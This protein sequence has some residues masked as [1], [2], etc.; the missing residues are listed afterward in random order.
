MTSLYVQRAKSS[1]RDWQQADL[2]ETT[3]EI[4]LIVPNMILVD[5]SEQINIKYTIKATY[6]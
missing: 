3:S 6:E 2:D 5:I 4:N 1:E